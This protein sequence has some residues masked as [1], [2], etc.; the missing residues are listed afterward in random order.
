MNSLQVLETVDPEEWNNDVML[1]NGCCFHSY[2]W[3][4]FSTEQ[5]NSKPLYFRWYDES[6]SLR[7][8]AFGLLKIKSLAGVPVYKTLS[9]GSFPVSDNDNA[10]Q[11]MV[12]AVI[13]YSHKN[14]ITSLGIHSFGTPF[15]TEILKQLDFSVEKR[16]EFLL[17][18]DMAEDDL[19]KKVHSKKRNLIR[20]GQKAKLRVEK[21]IRLDQLMQ[22]RELALETQ[23][24]KRSQGIPFPEVGGEPYYRLL[25]S[26]LIDIGLGRLY[27]AFDGDQPMAGSFFVN[28]NKSAYYMLSSANDQGLKNSAPDLILWTCITDYQREG[29]KICNLGGVSEKD[30]NGQPLEESGLYHFKK[31]FSADEHL[32]YKGTLILKPIT[33]KIYTF[34]R[35]TK[36]MFVK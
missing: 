11:S 1:L 3:S 28:Y 15:G 5:N 9:F 8:L 6:G 21:A 29:Y 2:E 30:L 18:I 13:S 16:W 33:N 4:L 36:S 34:I 12:N 31:R 35:K 26:K 24:R 22:L 19:W 25:K 23:E 32:C 10:T 7:C 27:L 14:N 20:K 17:D